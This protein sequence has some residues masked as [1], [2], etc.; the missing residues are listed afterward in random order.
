MCV[1]AHACAGLPAEVRPILEVSGHS[2]ENLPSHLMQEKNIAQLRVS[3]ANSAQ[4]G[5][6][7]YFFLGNT[8]SLKRAGC[9]PSPG[10]DLLIY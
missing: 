10:E 8:H 3:A 9:L 7:D 5:L 6:G 2:A 4:I 1:C